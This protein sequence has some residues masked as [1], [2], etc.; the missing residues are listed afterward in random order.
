MR[1]FEIHLNGNMFQPSYTLEVENEKKAIKKAVKEAKFNKNSTVDIFEV[2]GNE[3][4]SGT[5]R[6]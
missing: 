4:V 1:I 3:F 2:G 5:I 6:I